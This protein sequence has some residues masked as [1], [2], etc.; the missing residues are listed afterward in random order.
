VGSESVKRDTKYLSGVPKLTAGIVYCR[1]DVKVAVATVLAILLALETDRSF[2]M[3]ALNPVAPVNDSSDESQEEG[4]SQVK[5]MQSGRRLL[6]V[7]PAIHCKF[8]FRP[9]N[10]MVTSKAHRTFHLA[11]ANGRAFPLRC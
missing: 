6:A 5:T 7:A 8:C 3:L 9:S 2:G 4:N 1:V 11:S 10:T